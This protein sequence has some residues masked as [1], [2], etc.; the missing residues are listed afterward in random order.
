MSNDYLVQTAQGRRRQRLVRPLQSPLQALRFTAEPA[1]FQVSGTIKTLPQLREHLQTAIQLEHT[2]IP[3]YLTTL[4]TLDERRNRFAYQAIQGV[5]MEEMLHM[6]QVCNI[7]NALGGSPAINT[8]HF[9]R[10]TRPRCP[11]AT[12]RSRCRCKNSRPTP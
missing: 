6:I 10:N 8:P 4:Y 1:E 3:P 7:L 5:V 11:T 12:T 9:I 2:T